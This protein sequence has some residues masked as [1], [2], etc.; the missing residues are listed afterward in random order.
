[1]FKVVWDK[2][3]TVRLTMASMGGALNVSPRPVFF[4]E[5]DILGLDRLGWKYPKCQAP[6]MWACD[7]RYFYCG[8]MVMEVKGGNLLDAPII[9]VVP[10]KEALDISPVDM[11]YLRKRNEDSLFLLEH[12]AMDFIN[13]TYRRYKG[14]R[15][16]TEKNPDVDFQ[17]LA[18]RLEKKTKE[19]HVVVKEDCDSFD[20]MPLSEAEAQ[21][22]A[23]ILSSKVDLFISSFSGGKD[24]QVV[25]DLCARVIPS[26]DF[27]VIYSDTGYE[28]PTSLALYKELEE[29]Y[30]PLYPG[31]KFY[32]AS[33]EQSVLSYWDRMGSPSRM[34]RWCCAVM[35]TA[36][37]YRKLKDIAGLNKQPTVVAFEGVRA[38]ESDRRSQYQRFGKGVK[39]NNVMNARPILDWNS[40]EIYL[41]ILFRD[42]PFNRA[43]R[44]GLARVG[45]SICPFS[46]DWSEH[47]VSKLYPSSITPF[48]EHLYRMTEVLS[49]NTQ[50]EKDDYIK[51]GNWK[52]RAG[53]KTSNP[54]GSSLQF[55]TTSP[56]FKA[57]LIAPKENLLTWLKPLGTVS[58]FDSSPST[59]SGTITYLH[60]SY[61]LH[62]SISGEKTTLEIN[63]VGDDVIFQGL[64]KRVLYK[65]T[66]CVHCEV[67][68]VECPTGALVVTPIVK[69][70]SVKCIHCKKCL[71]F[72]DRGCVMANSINISET[73][74]KNNKSMATSGI[75]RY[76]TFGL[77]DKWVGDFFGNHEMFFKGENQ[78]GTKMVPACVNWF[79]E[80]EIL[81]P[82]DKVISPLGEV[83]RS[84]YLDNPKKIW[85][86]MWINMS[87]NS[88]I[89]SFYT[90]TIQFNRAYTK[91]DILERMQMKF[92]NIAKNTLSNPVGALC[93]MFGIG[94]ETIIGDELKQGIIAAKGRT[95]ET[96]KREPYNEISSTAVA[97]SLYKFA[98]KQGRKSLT[99]SEFYNENQTEGVY[100]QF[101]VDRVTFEKILRSLQEESHHVLTVEL[102]MGL[103]NINL[104]DDLSSFDVLKALL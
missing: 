48:V 10:G 72:K 97:Y 45:C 21:G 37:L 26:E 98:E 4:E 99:V 60:N 82:R 96:V 68:E 66:Y 30:R 14:L 74:S 24:S 86:I 8:E 53:G 2:N 63:N 83:L 39:H 42:I 27:L 64:I 77:K 46:S 44:D 11:E 35:K 104:R 58:I 103:D 87:E 59:M 80:C 28:L 50:K 75:D 34:H 6:L 69:I 20:I 52:L 32:T 15:E 43:Y 40:T 12:E 56:D 67:C 29:Y 51:S 36:P 19:E 94:E 41:Y 81:D 61:P 100:R 76:S 85:E 102:N 57:E 89:I 88:Q 73:L 101:G 95:V 17:Q 3:N 78:L 92:E 79:R 1:M 25:L 49:I 55:I 84:H 47:L 31:L 9:S 93:N 38:E 65:T 22:K 62:I 91:P 23:P 16:V 70:N 5:L 18:Q 90:S 7:R 54:E 71:T 13:Q 33:N